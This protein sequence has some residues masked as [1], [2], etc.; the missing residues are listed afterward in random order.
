MPNQRSADRHLLNVYLEVRD[1]ETGEA[2]GRVVDLT[3]AG[4]RMVAD[5][6][7]D[8]QRDYQLLITTDIGAAGRQTIRLDARCTWTG[9]D[10]NP[11]LLVA[12]FAFEHLRP[13][14]Q[15][16]LARVIRQFSFERT[17]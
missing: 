17:C 5:R 7:I 12:G 11:D 1:A 9:R 4:M 10:T 3:T 6:P 14:Q 16:M 2:V 15:T 8:D 13:S